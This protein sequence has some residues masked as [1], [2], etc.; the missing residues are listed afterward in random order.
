MVS[1]SRAWRMTRLPRELL[2]VEHVQR[3]VEVE[4]HQVGDVD[5]RRDRPEADRLQPALQPV[6]A[7][8]RSSRRGSGGRPRSG[9]GCRAWPRSRASTGSGW[10]TLPVTR[11]AL[12][13][14][15]VPTPAAARSRAMPCTP[16]QSPRLGVT[17]ISITASS[18]PS[19]SAAGMPVARLGRQVDDAAMVLAELQLAAGAQ[20]AVA[21]L[22]ADLARLE[23]Q[24]G[25]G[26][27]AAG[28]R[29]DALHA[30]ARVGRAADDLD[31]RPRRCRPCRRAAG[32]RWD[33]ARPRPRSRPRS[34]QRL[35]RVGRCLDLEAE[36][37]QRVAHLGRATRRCR[38]AP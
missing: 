34:L 22:A 18:R 2:R 12:N 1:P 7:R 28:R 33:A 14:F 13:G 37:G 36:H 4:G 16:S 5:Q 24:V 35:G 31:A 9:R 6:R 17:L 29:E 26:D 23:V 27:V 19:A 38:D 15:S 11:S 25:A 30:G 20:H 10:R 3:P 32:R 21:V 8:G